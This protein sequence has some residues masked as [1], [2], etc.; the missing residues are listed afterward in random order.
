MKDGVCDLP[1]QHNASPGWIYLGIAAYLGTVCAHW[2]RWAFVLYSVCVSVGVPTFAKRKHYFPSGGSYYIHITLESVIDWPNNRHILIKFTWSQA[3]LN[4]KQLT[5][6]FWAYLYVCLESMCMLCRH[7]P[8]WTSTE[9]QGVL[10]MDFIHLH[11]IHLPRA[12]GAL[13]IF[14]SVISTVCLSIC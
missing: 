5:F 6:L 8:K 10:I 12:P 1:R 4:L 9:A 11:H 7:V 14:H 13:T 2:L 3:V